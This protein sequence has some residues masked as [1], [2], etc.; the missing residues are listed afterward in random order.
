MLEMRD[1]TRE[2]RVEGLDVLRWMIRMAISQGKK[3]IHLSYSTACSASSSRSRSWE[4]AQL[5]DSTVR[6]T[7]T[8]LDSGVCL[9][10]YS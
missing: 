10:S 4:S 8:S 9:A 6:R 1:R 7:L 3:N 2:K 5:A